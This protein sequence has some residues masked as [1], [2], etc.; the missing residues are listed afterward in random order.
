MGIMGTTADGRHEEMLAL[1]ALHDSERLL[2][3]IDVA[4]DHIQRV[5]R[6][7]IQANAPESLP[8]PIPSPLFPREI[9]SSSSIIPPHSS[10]FVISEIL[11]FSALPSSDEELSLN[12]ILG[13]L[14][15]LK[16]TIQV[17]QFFPRSY[18]SQRFNAE[19]SFDITENSDTFN[20]LKSFIKKYSY[21]GEEPSWAIHASFEVDTFQSYDAP[22]FLKYLAVRIGQHTDDDDDKNEVE[23]EGGT[24][25]CGSNVSEGTFNGKASSETV[26]TSTTGSDGKDSSSSS[27]TENGTIKPTVKATGTSNGTTVKGPSCPI[28]VNG[29]TTTTTKTTNNGSINGPT[30]H[31]KASTNG[32]HLPQDNNNKAPLSSRSRRRPFFPQYQFH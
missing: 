25:S 11:I 28:P 23:G 22:D 13:R 16:T 2:A 30:T 18:F 17:N 8:S 12:L 9:H 21:Y 7:Q 10:P 31:C 5:Y 14:N 1:Q 32:K 15:S 27:P 19:K 4:R 26:P 24:D 6:V 20:T 29:T 3:Q